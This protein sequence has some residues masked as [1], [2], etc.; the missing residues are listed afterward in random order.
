MAGTRS[1]SAKAEGFDFDGW[2]LDVFS[3]NGDEPYLPSAQS[4]WFHI[5]EMYC[6]DPAF[7]MRMIDAGHLLEAMMTATEMHQ[8][9][10]GMRPVLVRLA[11][12]EVAEVS[13]RAQ[14]WLDLFY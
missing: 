3:Q 6:E 8:A 2:V 9:V 13:G 1:P 12:M 11:G 5:H 7:V 10:E 14:H 4:F